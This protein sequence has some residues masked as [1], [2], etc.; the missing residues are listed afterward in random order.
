MSNVFHEH[1]GSLGAIEFT[2]VPFTPKRLFWLFGI[3]PGAIRAA[4]AHRACH[5]LLTCMTGSLTADVTTRDTQLTSHSMTAGSTLH[6]EPLQ[7][8]ELLDFSHDAVLAV[9]A[10]EHYDAAEYIDSWDELREL[11]GTGYKD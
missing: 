2:N 6:L 10:S 5:Q 7:W 3:S 1:D 9:L 8:L 11:W 4:H